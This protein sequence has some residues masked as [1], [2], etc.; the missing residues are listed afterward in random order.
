MA[1]LADLIEECAKVLRIPILNIDQVHAALLACALPHAADVLTT[2]TRF[3]YP[4]YKVRQGI[5]FHLESRLTHDVPDEMYNS[6]R[7]AIRTAK[8]LPPIPNTEKLKTIVG[9]AGL[10]NVIDVEACIRTAL[11]HCDPGAVLRHA[12]NRIRR[13]VYHIEAAFVGETNRCRQIL[14]QGA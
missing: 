14:L 12:C 8:H 3:V 9:R 6:I 7:T 5:C 10:K 2:D 4:P 11:W 1:G 13:D